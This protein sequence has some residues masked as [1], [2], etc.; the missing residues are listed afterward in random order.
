VSLTLDDDARGRI[1]AWL[2]RRAADP[3]RRQDRLHV[4]QVVPAFRDRVLWIA[5]AS[6]CLDEAARLRDELLPDWDVFVVFSLVLSWG[7]GP[8]RPR[9]MERWMRVVDH[10]PPALHAWCGTTASG[11]ATVLGNVRIYE[12]GITVP[13]RCVTSKFVATWKNDGEPGWRRSLWWRSAPQSSP[14]PTGFTRLRL[15]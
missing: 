1:R 11:P 2:E 15:E 5:A 6:L 13:C 7:G 10:A 12:T 14:A 8:P 3:A 9:S 4:D